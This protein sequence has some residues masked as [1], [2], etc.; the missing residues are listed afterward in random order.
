[1]LASLLNIVILI[2]IPP[3]NPHFSVETTRRTVPVFRVFFLFNTLW[4]LCGWV[5]HVFEKYKVR[6]AC[7]P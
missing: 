2:A 4:W 5:V 3:T 7:S 1:M 6:V